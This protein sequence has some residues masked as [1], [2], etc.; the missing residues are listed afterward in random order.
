ME[1]ATHHRY[2]GLPLDQDDTFRLIR[3][4]P[5]RG[6]EPL[7][8]RLE[9]SQLNDPPPYEALSYVWGDASH[10]TTITILDPDSS[11]NDPVQAPVTINCHAALKRLRHPHTSRTLWVDAICIN[12]SH[13]PER[14]H[15]LSLMGRIY[16]T[17]RRV[18]VHLGEAA[19]ASDDV[20]RWIRQ[21]HWPAAANDDAANAAANAA[22]QRAQLHIIEPPAARAARPDD[23]SI[24][25]LLRRPW[26]HR[27]WVLQEIALAR[28]AV[29]VCGG[30]AEEEEEEEAV[31][32]EC[33][34]AFR[35]WLW[36]SRRAGSTTYARPIIGSL[37]SWADLL[38]VLAAT[39]H[40]GAS[41][42]RDKLYALLPLFD[43]AEETSAGAR[44]SSVSSLRPD[45][46][47]ATAVVFTDLAARLLEVH[48]LELLRWVVSPARVAGL[49][50]WVPDWSVNARSRQLES[51]RATP[52]RAGF[53]HDILL[54]WEQ[55][56][57]G[58]IVKHP[59]T[60]T[61]KYINTDGDETVALNV[62]G[63]CLGAIKTLGDVCEVEH[64]RSPS[65]DWTS[66]LASIKNIGQLSPPADSQI[67]SESKDELSSFLITLATGLA[68]PHS[69]KNALK[70]ADV[71]DITKN[72]HASF[73][74]GDETLFRDK[75]RDF[76]GSDQQSSSMISNCDGRRL[77]VTNTDYVGLAPA[78]ASVGDIV[79]VIEN[80]SVP[81]VLRPP[82]GPPDGWKHSEGDEASASGATCDSK[83]VLQLVGEAYLQGVMGGE[84]WELV[85]NETSHW[86]IEELLIS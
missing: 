85:D 14:N 71:G 7:T 20:M 63:V 26:F 80:A 62:G 45:Y 23:A 77:F 65:G 74:M 42:P 18:A 24:A 31:R 35:Y 66:L 78:A 25:A 15:Q 57:R 34:L 3:L 52:F 4:Q 79:M 39:R 41:D 30:G 28:A 81:F 64:G 76:P 54:D 75:S 51:H 69:T 17:A 16:R 86:H 21:L 36:G 84:I 46:R 44:S 83:Q 56:K 5:G 55:W 58:L 1:H 8:M 38:E 47:L 40:C 22:A 72:E 9:N 60:L 50:S 27:V 73:F 32:W 6:D 49:P 67:V 33:F 68:H 82:S 10:T 29:V 43:R 53:R 11:N 13:L 70:T 19:D 48:G 2:T 37:P 59:K 61:S 12:Q